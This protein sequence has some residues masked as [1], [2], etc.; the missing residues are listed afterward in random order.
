[1]AELCEVPQKEDVYVLDAGAGTGILSAAIVEKICKDGKDTV[2]QIFLTCYETDEELI[3]ALKDNLERVRKK[4]RHDYKIKLKVEISS[5]SFLVACADAYRDTLFN[6]QIKKF[7]IIVTNPPEEVLDKETAE[8][9]IYSDVCAKDADTTVLFTALSSVLL[10]EGGQ[11]CALLPTKTAYNASLAKFRR[12]LL[13]RVYI[14]RLHVFAKKAKAKYA[15]DPTKKS[16]IFKFRLGE[17]PENITVSSS[18]DD[19]SLEN[20]ILLPDFKYDYIVRGADKNVVLVKN[21]DELEI[22]NYVES[23]PETLSS[24]GLTMKTGLTL[25]SLVNNLNIK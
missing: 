18:Y 23:Q 12:V 25:E 2:K 14:E 24:L 20:I 8:A 16:M 6:D 22:L 11:I 13:S 17:A 1:M 5:E 21:N 10:K 3:P 4:C 15:A 7:D 19:G 9:A